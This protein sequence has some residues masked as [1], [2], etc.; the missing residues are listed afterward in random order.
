MRQNDSWGKMTKTN[1]FKLGLNILQ[2]FMQDQSNGS[3]HFSSVDD[4]VFLCIHFNSS[5]VKI[6]Q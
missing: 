6:I 1:M 5:S 4:R 2:T 3:V